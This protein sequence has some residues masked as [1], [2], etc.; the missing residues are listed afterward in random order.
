MWGRC[1][2]DRQQGVPISGIDRRSD[3]HGHEK[4][5][6]GSLDPRPPVGGLD[7]EL[8]VAASQVLNECVSADHDAC[9]A[10]AFGP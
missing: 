4:L 9:R 6:E 1:C 2:V 10:V 3:P 7:A 5:S 8:V